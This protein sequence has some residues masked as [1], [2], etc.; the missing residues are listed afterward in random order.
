[1]NYKR[2]CRKFHIKKLTSLTT[3]NYYNIFYIT[4]PRRPTNTKAQSWAPLTSAHIATAIINMYQVYILFYIVLTLNSRQKVWTIYFLH[5]RAFF[6]YVLFIIF[7]LKLGFYALKM[8][9]VVGA[10]AYAYGVACQF[11]IRS[12]KILF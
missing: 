2:W 9:I 7:V 10:V 6:I 4:P 11:T 8:S 1:M 5:G 3:L 12:H